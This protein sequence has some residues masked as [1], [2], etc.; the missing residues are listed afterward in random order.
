[1][2]DKE[3]EAKQLTIARRELLFVVARSVMPFFM[4]CG[5]VFFYAS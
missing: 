3:T 4:P 5:W 1:M 2:I